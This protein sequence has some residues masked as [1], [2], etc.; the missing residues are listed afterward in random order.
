MEMWTQ[1]FENCLLYNNTK[2]VQDSTRVIITKFIIEK[3]WQAHT[4]KFLSL[5]FTFDLF[6]CFS[7]VIECIQCKFGKP[8]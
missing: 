3:K 2:Y 8:L 1:K 4:Q 6:E 5:R 7:S